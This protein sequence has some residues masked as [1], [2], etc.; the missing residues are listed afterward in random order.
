MVLVKNK[1]IDLRKKLHDNPEVSMNEKNTKQILMNYI[2]ENAKNLELIDMG[3]WF[4]AVKRVNTMEKSIAFRADYDAVLCADGSPRHLCGH[5]GHSAILAGFATWLDSAKV[6]RDVFLIFQPGEEIGAGAE[7]CA[8]IIEENSI[9]EVYGFHNI[10]GYEKNEVLLLDHTFACAS[11]GLEIKLFGKES[12]A[13]YPENGINP[14][15]A[16]SEIIRNMNAIINEKH[17]GIVL[18]TVIGIEAGSDS[19]G[20]SAGKG[21]LKLTLRA[22]FQNEYDDFVSRIE[23]VAEDLTK[24]NGLKWEI[25]RI[26]EFPATINDISCVNKIRTVVKDLKLKVINPPEPFR[27]SEDFGYYLQKTKGAFFGVGC[28]DNHAGLH[29]LE[30]KFEDDII[31]TVIEIYKKLC[32]S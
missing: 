18:G 12:H 13:A 4:Y 7:I 8:Q 10:P 1:I 22:E 17:R 31:E 6:D 15:A 20:V 32:F 25:S 3:V 24:D 29:T 21:I 9:D 11:T 14:A 27:W 30:Y 23:K 5:D 26:E 2:N 19:Y 28:G 16:I